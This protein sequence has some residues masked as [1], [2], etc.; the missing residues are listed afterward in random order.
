MV[1]ISNGPPEIRR[2]YFHKYYESHRDELLEYSKAYKKAN[3]EKVQA[4]NKE[5]GFKW[6]EEN[7]EKMRAYLRAYYIT[8]KEKLLDRARKWDKANPEKAAAYSRK[9]KG[10]TPEKVHE[11]YRNYYEANKE[12]EIERSLKWQKEHPERGRLSQHRRRTRLKGKGDYTI[13]ELKAQFEQQEG[14]CFYCGELLY[15]SFN[16][17]IHVDHMIPLSRGGSNTIENIVIS[18]ATC[19]L[20]KGT[21]T[22][23]EFTRSLSFKKA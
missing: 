6:R 4:Y 12:K 13:D 14:F 7:S 19:N 23:E 2:E 21:K 1:G 9:W 15:A 3:C 11:S 20:R 22:S 8:N 5:Y 17:D 10:A 16:K 18:C